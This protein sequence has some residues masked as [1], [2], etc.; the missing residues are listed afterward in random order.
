MLIYGPTVR[1]PV[2][3]D[4]IVRFPGLR[5][6]AAGAVVV[7][8]YPKER[9]KDFVKR[10]VAVAGETLEVRG[11]SLLIDGKERIEPYARYEGTGQR[12]FGPHQVPDGHVFVLGDNRNEKLRLAL[13]GRCP[14]RRHPRTRRGRLREEP[15]GTRRSP[16]ASSYD[17]K[18]GAGGP[19]VRDPRRSAGPPG[20]ARRVGSLRYSGTS[21]R[22]VAVGWSI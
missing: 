4:V 15:Q 9:D 22:W 7:F 19:P 2:T 10:I 1:H 16:S 6:P 20:V 5:R 14:G 11:A 21:C 12:D 18:E 17:S 3:R 8:F 13:L